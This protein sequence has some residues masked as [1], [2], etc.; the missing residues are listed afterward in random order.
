MAS[1]KTAF[2]SIKEAKR[3]GSMD[4]K[5]FYN[6]VTEV[7]HLAEITGSAIPLGKATVEN[8]QEAANLIT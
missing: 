8:S 4:Y 1:W 5:D 2:D 7:G 3:S 6:F